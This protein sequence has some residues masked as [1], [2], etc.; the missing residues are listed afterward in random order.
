[1]GTELH[2]FHDKTLKRGRRMFDRADFTIHGNVYPYYLNVFIGPFIRERMQLS[3][4]LANSIRRR[5]KRR[6]VGKHW[7]TGLMLAE[8][9]TANTDSR[10]IED[11]RIP[12]DDEWRLLHVRKSFW[13]VSANVCNKKESRNWGLQKNY[14]YM[15]W[16]GTLYLEK[17]DAGRSLKFSCLEK[18]RRYRF[19]RVTGPLININ[20]WH[21][22]EG[23]LVRLIHTN[24]HYI[25][26]CIY[27]YIHHTY[28]Y[29]KNVIW[30]IERKKKN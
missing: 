28:I 3:K 11:G 9:T 5:S 25:Y 8:I 26:I 20:T 19:L 4:R 13:C 2:D 16:K 14:I 27:I 17:I 1:M 12:L 10:V 30:R 15:L 23:E 7:R 18:R 29:I 21:R 24:I 6:C 22:R